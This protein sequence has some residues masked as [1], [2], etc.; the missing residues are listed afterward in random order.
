MNTLKYFLYD[1]AGYNKIISQYIYSNIAS[2]PLI[3]FFR[4]ITQMG[5]V[6]FFPLH[7]ALL[8]LAFFIMLRRN[9]KN[10]I[11]QGISYARCL[12]LLFLNILVA[13]IIIETMKRV[14]QHL[15]PYCILDFNMKK[16]LLYLISYPQKSC[17]SSFPSGHTAYVCV[18]IISF[19][20]IL[21]R[22]LKAIGVFLIMFVGIS[23][24]ILGK[25][26]IA[27]ITYSYLIV[28]LIINPLNNLLVIKYFPK[29]QFSV[30]KF[31][32]KIF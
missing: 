19:W 7:L 23:R 11:Q 30:K 22:G 6:Y 8:L 9:D 13:V 32:E 27:D 3:I 18:F 12:S 24:V 16:Y 4:S 21:N 29:Y 25:H 26:F 14:F 1:W 10:A 20:Q 2:K 15:R 28:L 5:N 31:L 17:H